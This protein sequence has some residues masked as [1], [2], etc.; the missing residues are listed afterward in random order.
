M[1]TWQFDFCLEVVLTQRLLA[2][3]LWCWEALLLLHNTKALRNSSLSAG[4]KAFQWRH[5]L[6]LYELNSQ[7][8]GEAAAG[9]V[10]AAC[11]HLGLWKQV[12]Q[13]GDEEMVL[14]AAITACEKWQKVAACCS[15]K[16][17]FLRGDDASRCTKYMYRYM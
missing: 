12:L 2:G 14:G 8:G 3:F 9:P 15:D 5:S 11:A 1:D 7:C 16:I 13:L 17:F 6:K 10:A 4:E